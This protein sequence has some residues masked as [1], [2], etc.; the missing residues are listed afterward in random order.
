VVHALHLVALLNTLAKQ[1][2]LKGRGEIASVEGARLGRRGLGFIF[3]CVSSVA[4]ELCVAPGA[5]LGGLDLHH[6]L[7]DHVLPLRD[8]RDLISQWVGRVE[9]LGRPREVGSLSVELL[10]HRGFLSENGPI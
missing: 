7:A 5:H 4:W 8:G 1:L 3:G 2:R 10:R 6:L 9:V